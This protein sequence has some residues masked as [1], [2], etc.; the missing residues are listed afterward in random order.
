MYNGYKIEFKIAYLS[1]I[2]NISTLLSTLWGIGLRNY[3]A[4]NIAGGKKESTA[5]PLKADDTSVY[6]EF[7]KF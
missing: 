4:I 1:T 3:N 7:L 6:Y 2:L 5:S